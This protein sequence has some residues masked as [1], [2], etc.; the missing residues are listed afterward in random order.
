MYKGRRGTSREAGGVCGCGA[1]SCFT[2]TVYVLI[3]V[4][5][6]ECELYL[7]PAIGDF[8]VDVSALWSETEGGGASALQLLSHQQTL[9]LQYEWGSFTVGWPA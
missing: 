1:G 4:C 2:N 5:P 6:A 8:V 9:V 3:R 7:A